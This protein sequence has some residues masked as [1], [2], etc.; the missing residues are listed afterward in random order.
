MQR[1]IC[2]V[3]GQLGQL[4]VYHL[5]Q[6]QYH[7]QKQTKIEQKID[8][9]KVWENYNNKTFSWTKIRHKLK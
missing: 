3:L 1:K 7:K 9:Q 2:K 5:G 4:Q 6:L 8:Q